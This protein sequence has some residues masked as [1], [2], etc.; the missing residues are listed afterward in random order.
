VTALDG[1]NSIVTSYAG[2]VHFTISDG[3][4]L[5]PVNSTLTSG[6]GTFS[7]TLKT[8]GNQT[9]TAT[10]TV[11]ASITGTSNT[12]G[13]SAA[14]A[15]HFAI[16][17]PAAV[18]AGSVFSF[19]VTGL[20]QF[21]NTATNY[22][23][24]VHFTSSDGTAVL[25]GNSSLT[26]G[27]GALSATLK[28]G[29]NQTITA[30]DTVSASITG[31]SNVIAVALPPDLTI[32][33]SH[34][35][36]FFLGETGAIYSLMVSNVGAGSTIGTITAA[37]TLPA[38]LSATSITGTGW[39]C[40]VATLACTRGDALSA[41]SS[42]PA[43]TVTV[44]VASNA[45]A[46]V[47]NTAMVS[48]G[49]ELNVVND[50]VTDVTT[51]TQPPDFMLSLTLTTI[52][53]KAGQQASYALTVTPQNGAFANPIVFSATGLP[54]KTSFVFTPPSVTPGANP[55]TS[56]LVVSTSAGNPLLV[57][58]S[59]RACMPNYALLLPFAGLVLSGFSLRKRRGKKGWVLVVML[60]CG[61]LGLYGCAGAQGNFANTGTPPGTYTVTITATSGATQHSAPVTL[62]VQR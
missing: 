22:A 19:T 36:N 34:T 51:V 6:V 40:S 16:A 60:L 7:T 28:A 61:G 59:G 50:A 54:A 27:T 53:V 17:A 52:T 57:Q 58:N 48:G 3:V 38:G 44:N 49:G 62:I 26:N 20:D 56:T 55:A 47:T 45:A 11:A 2:T 42:F 32:A 4:A 43:I 10:D 15:T 33:K 23:G 35:G 9:V 14:A 13:V 18:T 25:P 24:T 41:G 46:S 29:G 39:T 12:I 30:T 21:G 37:D 1:N 8:A 5:V 31:T